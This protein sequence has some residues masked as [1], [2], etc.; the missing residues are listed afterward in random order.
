MIH[1]GERGR[2]ELG[3]RQTFGYLP[4]LLETSQSSTR[5]FFAIEGYVTF[6]KRTKFNEFVTTGV[7]AEKGS[8]LQSYF[9]VVLTTCVIMRIR[10]K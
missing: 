1:F 4:K 10:I 9:R 5:T 7:S 3:E 6:G 2:F 8:S